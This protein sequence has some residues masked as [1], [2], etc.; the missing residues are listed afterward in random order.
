MAPSNENGANTGGESKKKAS[1]YHTGDVEVVM[2]VE[3][4][5]REAAKISAAGAPL[6]PGAIVTIFDA[7]SLQFGNFPTLITD[8]SGG[9]LF[10]WYEVSPLQSYAPI[11]RQTRGHLW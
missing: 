1:G 8:G 2:S 7:G 4:V 6:W 11:D 9:A 3:A 5:A 10:S